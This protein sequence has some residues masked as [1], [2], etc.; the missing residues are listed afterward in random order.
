MVDIHPTLASVI[1]YADAI[2][3]EAEVHAGLQTQTSVKVKG[4]DG[5]AVEA[6]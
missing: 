1:N 6:P 3:G 2:M 4:L 5:G